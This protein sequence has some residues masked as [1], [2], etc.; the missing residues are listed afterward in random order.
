MNSSSEARLLGAG[1]TRSTRRGHGEMPRRE[2]LDTY[3]TRLCFVQAMETTWF[4]LLR[5]KEDG[6]YRT[7][8]L[9]KAHKNE[10]PALFIDGGY[11]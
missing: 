4:Q 3:Q 6:W 5:A 2:W 8:Q 10:T 11:A 9:N 7:Q 1:H